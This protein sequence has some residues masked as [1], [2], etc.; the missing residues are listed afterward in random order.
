MVIPDLK[1]VVGYIT[2]A[3]KIIFKNQD[4]KLDLVATFS[5]LL[6]KEISVNVYVFFAIDKKVFRV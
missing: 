5:M 3:M 6:L 1:C 4:F 2:S